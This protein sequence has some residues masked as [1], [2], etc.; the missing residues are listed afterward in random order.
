MQSLHFGEMALEDILDAPR[1]HGH[2]ILLTLATAYDDVMIGKIDI[3]HPQAETLHQA[4]TSTIEKTCHQ[5]MHARKL[6][7]HHG[8]FPTGKD[9]RQ[10]TWAFGA[11][12]RTEFWQFLL[13]HVAIQEEQRVQSDILG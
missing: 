3:F 6:C 13:Q 8:D 7:Q 5:I 10:A 11:F 1:Q 4:E 9:C 2:T 12:K